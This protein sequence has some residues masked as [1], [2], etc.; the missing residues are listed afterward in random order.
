MTYR[1]ANFVLNTDTRTLECEGKPVRLERQV[2]DLLE[3]LIRN[4]DR[5]LSKDDLIELVWGGRIVSDAAIST[6]I[7]GARRAV[8]DDGRRQEIIQTQARAG[9]R[10]IADVQEGD[11]A[12][13]MQRPRPETTGTPTLA[14]LPFTNLQAGTSDD[15]L[16]RGLAEEIIATLSRTRWLRM[17]AAGAS[18]AIRGAMPDARRA[19]SDLG[20]RYVLQGLFLRAEDR[21]RLNA[22]LLDGETGQYLKAF[23]IDRAYSDLFRVI[24]EISIH[25]VAEI[26]PELAKRELE[27]ARR[28][29][30]A[31]LDAWELYLRGQ[32]LLRQNTW[33]TCQQAARLLSVSVERDPSLAPAHARLAT[34]SIHEGYY[35][36]TGRPL[37]DV[38]SDAIAH[39]RRALR[40]DS[41]E[42]LAYDALASAHQLAG[43]TEE[44]ERY[45]RQGIA[46]SPI[47]TAAY[48]TLIT[49]LAFQGRSRE[50][51]A[52]YDE[53]NLVASQDP[54]RSSAVMGVCMARFLLGDHDGSAMLAREHIALRPNWYGNRI[55]LAASL[56]HL[57]Q[58]DEAATAIADLLQLVPGLTLADMKRRTRLEK[59][60]HVEHLL[61]GLR[62]AG[63]HEGQ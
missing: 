38:V 13:A 42:A 46:L 4:R 51:I 21:V 23:K 24:D 22:T 26:M 62:L 17:I 18:D 55:F 58:Q 41:G 5:L 2:F 50:A 1:F 3:V 54:E 59:P 27:R 60:E 29:R 7:N 12:P 19:S 10:F 35:G 61:T 9:F 6:R 11:P 52:L 16:G 14:V 43:R 20:V 45:A 30:T 28:N 53:M 40:A 63:L 48:G 37:T 47:C 32:D 49:T 39:A 33:E 31:D 57:R 44:A 15:L 8:G 36:W 25:V 34:C 56:G